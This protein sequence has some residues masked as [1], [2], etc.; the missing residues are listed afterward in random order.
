ME[1]GHEKCRFGKDTGTKNSM[2]MVRIS[3]R[4]V[5]MQKRCTCLLQIMQKYLVNT[6]QIAARSA[7]QSS[8]TC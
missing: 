1:L 3:E 5:Q 7:R 4:E 6:A 8:H 2:I